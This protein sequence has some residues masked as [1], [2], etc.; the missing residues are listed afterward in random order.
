MDVADYPDTM[1]E[2]HISEALEECA[3]TLVRWKDIF[4]VA[5]HIASGERKIWDVPQEIL[6]EINKLFGY[7]CEELWIGEDGY[8]SPY[9]NVIQLIE[10]S[11]YEKP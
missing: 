4:I 9:K 11:A 8:S 10:T 1:Y 6:L 5:Q 3:D 7:V 2:H